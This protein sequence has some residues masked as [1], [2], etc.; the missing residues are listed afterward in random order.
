MNPLIYRRSSGKKKMVSLVEADDNGLT[1]HISFPFSEHLFTAF[2]FRTS[3]N[4]FHYVRLQRLEW[5]FVV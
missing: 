3:K 4:Y 1:G 2:I 5:K